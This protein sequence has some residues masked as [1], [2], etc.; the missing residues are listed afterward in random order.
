MPWISLP[1]NHPLVIKAKE[2][3]EW[4]FIPYLVVLSKTGKLISK[5]GRD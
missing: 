3:F 5:T 1:L 4:K 2:E